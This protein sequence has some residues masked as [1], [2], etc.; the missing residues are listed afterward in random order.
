MVGA[1]LV[2]PVNAVDGDRLKKKL[3]EF[4]FPIYIAKASPF[5]SVSKF[6]MHKVA[7]N[8]YSK[9]LIRY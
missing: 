2:K 5:I 3:L 8:L 1:L 4:V 7:L 9:F 6:V